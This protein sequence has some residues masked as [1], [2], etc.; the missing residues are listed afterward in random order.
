MFSVGAKPKKERQLTHC[1][2]N[3]E[4]EER[5]QWKEDRTH[6]TAMLSVRETSSKVNLYSDEPGSKLYP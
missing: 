3:R 4:L 1:S 5:K 6:A 2:C